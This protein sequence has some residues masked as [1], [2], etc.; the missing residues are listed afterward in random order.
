MK[1]L[2][3]I[4]LSGF[5][6]ASAQNAPDF[7]M[8][9]TYGTEWNLYE[10]LEQGTTVV[11]DFFYVA[12]VPCQTQSPEIAIMYNDYMTSNMDVLVLG[13]SNRDD[14]ASVEQF[15]Q[16]YNI[17][18]PTAGDQGGGDT[19]TE[20]YQS[21]FSFFAWP[22]YAVVCPDTSLQGYVSPTVP[23]VPEI[24]AL[25]DECLGI[26][27]IDSGPKMSDYV[28]FHGN[29]L[30]VHSEQVLTIRIVDL[31]GREL[32]RFNGKLVGKSVH[33]PPNGISII[34]I[35]LQNHQFIHQKIFR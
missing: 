8:T 16:T 31:L 9:D 4:L 20:L 18:Y 5:S 10:Q 6:C 22:W 23:G 24:R 19:I 2:F 29:Q 21:W 12:C 32:S 3:T 1:H 30:M 13:I 28:S 11:L 7:S 35:E 17:T 15:D 26:S 33:V 25:V 34:T 27:S 14:N